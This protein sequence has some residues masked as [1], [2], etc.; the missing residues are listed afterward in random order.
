[1]LAM[2]VVPPP[3]AIASPADYAAGGCAANT[4]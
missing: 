2:P 4:D 3:E 1:V